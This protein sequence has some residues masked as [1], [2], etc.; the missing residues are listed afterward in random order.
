[1]N[2]RGMKLGAIPAVLLMA[3]TMAAA[4]GEEKSVANPKE[5]HEAYAK[6]EQQVVAQL[7][8][9]QTPETAFDYV[10]FYMSGPVVVLTGFTTKGPLKQEAEGNVKS[11]KWVE[12]VVNEIE[13]LPVTSELRSLRL[14][15]LGRLSEALPQSFPAGHANI[16]IKVTGDFQ[17]TLVGVIDPLNKLSLESAVVQIK[18]MPLVKS[19]T[20]QVL[21]T[22]N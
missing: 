2:L 3:A 7:L 19:V 13:I 20:N 21:A 5:I 14:S 16:R 12:H 8:R 11:L 17:V 15:I 1:M 22:L 18:Q 10:N 6:Q 4:G 9:I